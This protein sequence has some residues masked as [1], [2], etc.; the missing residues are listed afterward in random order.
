M[1]PFNNRLKKYIHLSKQPSQKLHKTHVLGGDN[2][3]YSFKPNDE[4]LL[5]RSFIVKKPQESRYLPQI[6]L[7]NEGFHQLSDI[8]QM[9]NKRMLPI[10]NIL[11]PRYKTELEQSEIS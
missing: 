11:L 2:L 8:K 5:E 9:Y 4:Y 7:K 6:N 1:N 10:D 3:S